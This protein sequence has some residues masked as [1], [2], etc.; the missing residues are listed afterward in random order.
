[1]SLQ[2]TL[3]SPLLLTA[4]PHTTHQQIGLPIYCEPP[5][6]QIWCWRPVE[7]FPWRVSG[8]SLVER[9]GK[10]TNPKYNKIYISNQKKA[11]TARKRRLMETL[12]KCVCFA[13]VSKI[14]WW[15]KVNC[16][17]WYSS[18]D[19]LF[20]KDYNKQNYLLARQIEVKVSSSAVRRITYKTACLGKVS[21]GAFQKC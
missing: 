12:Q 13:H 16:V 3:P 18:W 9:G 17:Q 2:D 5:N 15:D 20:Q 6:V 1:M 11:F 8:A 14:V 4:G 21:W 7:I 10:K 19:R